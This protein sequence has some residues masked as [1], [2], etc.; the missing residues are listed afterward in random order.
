VIFK[1]KDY[2][3]H[4]QQKI[5]TLAADC[6]SATS[7]SMCS[8]T[9][10]S[11]FAATA[12]SALTA[13]VTAREI[14]ALPSTAGGRGCRL[15]QLGPALE[16]SRPLPGIDRKV[17]ARLSTLRP[18]THGVYRDFGTHHRPMLSVDKQFMTMTMQL[19]P[20]FQLPTFA[21]V[22]APWN[23]PSQITPS[24][25]PEVHRNNEKSLHQ[26]PPTGLT[27]GWPASDNLVAAAPPR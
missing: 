21:P 26:E 23:S 27:F 11:A 4:N 9:A 8:P 13:A 14:G 25:R 17:S 24:T 6:S 2:R 7:C 22:P 12:S 5:M 16:L 18:G 1:W 3:H 15:P 10:S 19:Y 20:L